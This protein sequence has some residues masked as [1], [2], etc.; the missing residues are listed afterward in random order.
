MYFYTFRTLR[1]RLLDPPLYSMNKNRVEIIRGILTIEKE[2][3]KIIVNLS[4]R[5]FCRTTKFNP[6]KEVLEFPQPKS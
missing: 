2:F 1:D 4:D 6:Q 3:S 5:R